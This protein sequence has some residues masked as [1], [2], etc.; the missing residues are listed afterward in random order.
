MRAPA[1]NRLRAVAALAMGIAALWQGSAFVSCPAQDPMS[2]KSSRDASK[3]AMR[4]RQGGRFNLWQ[5]FMPRIKGAKMMA[6]FRPRKSPGSSKARQMPRRYELYDVL[7]EMTAKVPTYTIIEEPEEPILPVFDVGIKERYPWAG[8]LENV[9]WR[10]IEEEE[11]YYTAMEPLYGSS[12]HQ[13]SA[14]SG[15]TQ[16]YE[17]RRGYERASKFPMWLN[18]PVKGA[19][20]GKEK[21]NNLQWQKDRRPR[22]WQLTPKQ[23]ALGIHKYAVADVPRFGPM[24][25]DENKE[26]C[27]RTGFRF[28][29]YMEEGELDDTEPV[30][31]GLDAALDDL[32]D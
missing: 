32:E 10:K 11:N 21:I 9:N 31:D 2:P 18:I 1:G 23:T 16:T 5:S 30:D 17:Q 7:E 12:V 22:R 25:E 13:N 24:Y 26:N 15:R 19:E 28:R 8:P 27:L 29:N 3:V 6:I 20:I 14:P 4:G